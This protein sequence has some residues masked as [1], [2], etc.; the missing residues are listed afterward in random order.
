MLQPYL[1]N[2]YGYVALWNVGLNPARE[3]GSIPT[4]STKGT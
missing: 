1:A 2:N 3:V 4:I